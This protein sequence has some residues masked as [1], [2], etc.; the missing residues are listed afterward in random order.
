[1]LVICDKTGIEFQAE[2]KRQKNHPMASAFLDEAAKDNGRYVGASRKAKEILAEIKAAGYTDINEAIAEAKAVY[3]DWCENGNT[4]RRVMSRKERL[5]RSEK[6]TAFARKLTS[7]GVSYE[8]LNDGVG[9][10]YN[11][12]M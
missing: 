7:G 9:G 12:G 6:Y 8:E 1:M 4:S 10:P 3:A 5:A 11:A 2:S